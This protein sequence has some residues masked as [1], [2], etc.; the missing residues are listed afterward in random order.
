MNG[1][2]LDGWK[3]IAEYVGKS[4]R[5]V[6]RWEKEEGFPVRRVMS[7]KSVF[8][9]VDEIDNWLKERSKRSFKNKKTVEDIQSEFSEFTVQNDIPENENNLENQTQSLK[10][11][12][13]LKPFSI[14]VFF[15]IVL[16]FAGYNFVSYKK[17]R[18]LQKRKLLFE[19]DGG[20]SVVKIK[21]QNGNVLKTFCC[22]QPV[23][24]SFL[25]P[26]GNYHHFQFVDVNNDNILD[27]VYGEVCPDKRQ[28]IKIFVTND[29]GELVERNTI[30]LGLNYRIEKDDYT[31]RNFLI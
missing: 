5:T 18:M 26:I 27:L 13:S 19:L 12:I 4:V 23:Y 2:I 20:G 15:L 21:D 8:A 9:Y 14:G 30:N 22:G 31:Y 28:E 16:F 3:E 25:F 17:I 7:K 11:S 24:K 29:D 10:R 6:Q 1:K